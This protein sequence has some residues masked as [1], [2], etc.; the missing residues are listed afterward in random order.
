MYA[1]IMA[2]GS[3]ERFWPR[4]RK[5]SPKQLLNIAGEST[6][7]QETA[8]RLG[9]LVPPER[10]LIATSALLA[11]EIRRQLPAIPEENIIAEPVGRNTAPCVGLTAVYV[12]RLDPDAVMAVLT[13]DH[14]IKPAADFRAALE[15]AGKVCVERDSLVTFGIVPDRP[16]TG[17]GYIEAGN[18]VV[19]EG[20]LAARKVLRFVE[21]PDLATAERFAADGNFR[22]N[23]GMFVFTVKAI[24]EEFESHAPKIHAGLME[25][26]NAIGTPDE[27]KTIETVFPKFPSIS[28]D[29]AIMEKS[30]RALTVDATFEWSDVGS[31]SSLYDLL[32]R[33]DDGNVVTGRAVLLDAKNCL[34]DSPKKLVAA[35][36]V[37]DLVIVETDDALLVCHRDRAQEVK[38]IVDFLKDEKLEEFL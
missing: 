25:I 9:P 29:Y 27:A 12:S 11:A 6:M 15:F 38:K 14:I 34:V 21:K 24:L 4:S 8:R 23:S 36:G 30:S 2:G 20:P 13:A 37:E 31:W 32:A 3:G 5:S 22:F 35:L 16:E 26:G 28:I 18:P 10:I 7:I 17:Y 33:D 19:E 1:V